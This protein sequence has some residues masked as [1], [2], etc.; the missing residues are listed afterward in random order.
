MEKLELRLNESETLLDRL[1]EEGVDIAHDCGGVLACAS[2]RV[3]VR[4]GGDRLLAASDDELDMLERVGEAP[5]AR[6]A[7]QVK[8]VAAELV[9]E[10][11]RE[12]PVRERPL[13]GAVAPVSVSPRAARHLAAQ[14]AKHPGA[15]GVRLAVQAAGC[16]GLR[17]RVDPAEVLGEADTVFE[18]GGV[19]VVVDAA[20]LPYLHGTTVDLA[21]EGLAR[22]LRFHNPGA[23]QHCGCGESFG[24]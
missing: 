16:S 15:L 17:Y 5:N 8:G 18:S 9:I 24:F 10:I 2:C 20:S 11:P 22:R 19:R 13:I 12:A 6:L 4:E 7:C 3:L 21:D 1:R 14:L 23:R